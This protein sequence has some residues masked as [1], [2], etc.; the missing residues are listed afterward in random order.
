MT[1][2]PRAHTA[3]DALQP[4][5]L[6]PENIYGHLQ[7]LHWLRDHLAKTD[8]TVEFGCGTGALITVPLRSWGYDVSGIDLDHASIAHGRRLLE[9]AGLD[10]DA[11]TTTDLRDYPGPLDVVICSEVLEHLDDVTLGESLG[12]MREKLAPDGRLLITVPNGY[13]EFELENFLWTSTGLDTLFERMRDGRAA[14]A[15]RRLRARTI[16][17][18]EPENPMTVADSP[19]LQRF[20]WRSIHRTLAVAGFEVVEGRGAILVCGPF[21]DLLLSGVRSAMDLNQKLAQRFHKAASDFYLVA[22]KR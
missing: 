14:N 1:A 21:S 2:P 11:L 16:D 18:Q 9:G 12:L 19:H 8:R 15:M 22:H 7:R 20:T 4:V 5:V 17:W 6:P 10:S 13:S 3:S